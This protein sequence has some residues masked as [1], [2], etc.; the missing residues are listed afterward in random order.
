MTGASLALFVILGQAPAADPLDLIK[1]LGAPRFAEREA[2]ASALEQLGR[3]ALPALRTA[4]EQRDPE[5]RNRAAALLGRIEG[6]LLTV[7]S[8]VTLD[9]DDAPIGEVIRSFSEQSGIKL[10][11]MPETSP[12]WRN[13]RVTVHEPAALPFWKAIDRLCEAAHLQY[14][15]GMN[16]AQ[17]GREQTFA[18]FE[19]GGVRSSAPISDSGPFRVTVVT[20]RHQR[21]VMFPPTS[22]VIRNPANAGRPSQPVPVINEQFNAQ[23]QVVGEPRLALAQSGPLKISEAADDKGNTLVTPLNGNANAELRRS[24]YFGFA[25]GSTIQVQVAMNYPPQPGTSI[26]VLKGTVPVTV[27]TRKPGPL[28]V[29]LAGASGRSFQNDDVAMT[30]HDVRLQAANRPPTIEVTI[31]PNASSTSSSGDGGMNDGMMAGRPNSHQQQLEV[32]DA[33]GRPIAWYQSSFDAEGGRV[34]LSLANAEQA[35]TATELHYFS[36]VRASTEV[37]FEFADLPMP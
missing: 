28:I 30:V 33:Q 32:S 27:S 1:G 5:I 4:R 3:R 10:V 29:A 13:R 22:P 19:G 8:Q 9:F 6:S 18:L 14:N 12:S 37:A 16:M 21:D 25:T 36:L 31:R 15:A 20:L 26:K 24:G 34:T 11:L 23:L 2:A 17:N 7:P 35:A